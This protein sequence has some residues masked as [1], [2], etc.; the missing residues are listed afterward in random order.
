M[1]RQVDAHK[2]S[3]IKI[4]LIKLY[5]IISIHLTAMLDS[6][7]TFSKS[8]ACMFILPVSRIESQIN[9]YHKNNSLIFVVIFNYS[10]HFF[11]LNRLLRMKNIFRLSG[12]LVAVVFFSSCSKNNLSDSAF[13]QERLIKLS[14][15]LEQS[16]TLQ[17]LASSPSVERASL[18]TSQNNSIREEGH[19]NHSEKVAEKSNPQKSFKAIKAIKKMVREE[20][21]SPEEVNSGHSNNRSGLSERMKLG[22]LLA[23]VG[24][25]IMLILGILGPLYW[26]GA[27]VLVIG[28]VIIVMELLE[29]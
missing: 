20:K 17:Q 14:A 4:T 27:I 3:S 18:N 9:W 25:I 10:K 29:M 26:I 5:Q 15:E 24:L 13:H 23:A 22:I 21:I 16:N 1:V 19:K 6:E 7:L 8:K 12:L 11:K 2:I 28:L